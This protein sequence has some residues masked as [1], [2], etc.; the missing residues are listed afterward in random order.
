MKT[1]NYVMAA[2]SGGRHHTNHVGG[3]IDDHMEFL[4]QFDHHLDQI[5]I[6]HPFNDRETEAYHLSLKLAVKNSSIPVVILEQPNI[7]RSYGHW[8]RTF[9]E[10]NNFNYYIFIEDDYVPWI[11]NFDDILIEM[12]EKKK[13]SENCGFLCGLFAK[14]SEY[15]FLECKP[16][17][18]IA[19]GISSKDVLQTVWDKFGML[20]HDTDVTY[21]D[22]QTLFSNGFLK[23]GY[24]ICD[25][26]NEENRSL[27]Y[28]H[29]D[30]RLRWYSRTGAERKDIFVPIQFAVKPDPEQWKFA[31]YTQDNIFWPD[32]DADNME[33]GT[34]GRRKLIHT[35]FSP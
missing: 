32:P 4:H 13:E 31:L 33:H 30:R 11:D 15:G 23:C 17:A 7:G 2:W 34:Q 12:Y 26:L 14:G 35:T 19:N 16:H 9:K 21:H 24:K 22:G 25:Y 5:T 8:S 10:Y 6:A 18:A 29:D 20:P 3:Y 1:I 28:A 27:Y